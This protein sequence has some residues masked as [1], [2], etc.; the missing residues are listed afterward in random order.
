MKPWR[1]LVGVVLLSLLSATVVSAGM[2]IKWSR[3]NLTIGGG[4]TS[5]ERVH[6][7]GDLSLATPADQIDPPNENVSVSLFIN[8]SPDPN[9]PH[10]ELFYGAQILPGGISPTSTG[11]E[12]NQI[13][14]QQSGLEVFKITTQTGGWHVNFNDA[15][16]TLSSLNYSTI[17]VVIT[18]GDDSSGTTPIPMNQLGGTWTNN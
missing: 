3:C 8:S 1:I 12:L 17:Y 7:E 16:A 14:K 5:T 9:A 18:I 10:Y 13:G 2:R 4:T 15:R 6:L 11:W